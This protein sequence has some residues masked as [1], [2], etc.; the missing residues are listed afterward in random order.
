MDVTC[1]R[2]GTE[3]EFDE[4]LV[5]DR[6]TTVKCTNCGH[7]F[8]VFRPR[9]EA[10][11]ADESAR[12]FRLRT[13]SGETQSFESLKELQR[14]IVE[15][16]VSPEDEIA[17]SREGWKRLGDIA[18]LATFFDSAHASDR[19]LER[20]EPERGHAPQPAPAVAA[21]AA[22]SGKGTMLG[23]GG[24]A[25]A[26]ERGRGEAPARPDGPRPASVPPPPPAKPASI[27]PPLPPP[28]R[29]PSEPPTARP[30]RGDHTM[31]GLGGAPAADPVIPPPP[32]VPSVAPPAST[33][34]SRR[35]S[36]PRAD[37]R[38]PASVHLQLD[39]HDD[40]RPKQRN[41]TPV[42]L[43]LVVV[44]LFAGAAI[45]FWHGAQ[46]GTSE[47]ASASAPGDRFVT[48]G[49][50]AL[51]RD[52]PADYDDAVAQFTKALGLD[53]ADVRAQVGLARA[54]ALRAQGHLFEADDLEL[55]GG[56]DATSRGE[57]SILRRTAASEAAQARTDAEAAIR[58]GGGG[59]DAELALADA[60]RL[61]GERD[62][63]RSHLDRARTLARQPSAESLRVEALLTAQAHG[64]DLA[65]ARD[66]AAQAVAA[67]GD[68]LRARLLL[69]RASLAA[70]DGEAARR[71][72][73]AV[74]A[75][76]GTH[77]EALALRDRA[78]AM[79]GEGPAPP[80]S[81]VA[82]PSP[83][84]PTPTPAAPSPV[85]DARALERPTAPA[86][87]SGPSSAEHPSSTRDYG[88]LVREG[89]ERLERGQV[90]L[91]RQAFEAALRQRPAGPEATTGM[92][93]VLLNEGNVQGAIRQFQAAAS[94]GHGD[95]LIGLGDAYRRVG[96]SAQA[97]DAYRRY[98]Q[99]LPTG[100]SASLARHQIEV[101]GGA[102][103]GPS[104]GGTSGGGTSGGGTSDSLGGTTS[105]P[106]TR[107]P[108]TREPATREPSPRVDPPP[109]DT[110]A[111]D[112]EP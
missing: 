58:V 34:E 5:S 31:K 89:T 21:K 105:E 57:A 45:W 52:R 39:E 43:G 63:A 4:T 49:D 79:I 28:P 98:V 53:E 1:E 38:R 100:R 12:V 17:S 76:D 26:T 67:D 33:P 73:E 18:E 61:V 15:G 3:Y 62:L 78:M 44:A 47:A 11:R 109:T 90:G 84:P 64:G 74:L 111:I 10:P 23:M 22:R 107:E 36:A 48:L 91:A 6:G 8:K 104:G 112:S 103:G 87:A 95:A 85:E 96:Q 29:P 32:K 99:I 2:C 56:D 69:A 60:L 7:L 51:A 65:S 37:S 50:Q 55:R 30:S 93:Y 81:A 75:R 14:L 66:L 25:R 97:L 77:A 86:A 19:R 92:G 68:L 72:A 13:T 102:S 35:A 71:E 94:A 27:P 80:P 46:A 106:T 59:A 83:S 82:T 40:E 70:R 41:L 42:F 20:A 110:P 9:A 24:A 101:L 88:A 108:A 54:H 16:R